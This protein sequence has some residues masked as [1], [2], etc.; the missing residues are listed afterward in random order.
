[1]G[2]KSKNSIL[3]KFINSLSSRRIL[4]KLLLAF[5]CIFVFYFIVYEAYNYVLRPINMNNIPLIKFENCNVKSK[6]QT[7]DGITFSNQNKLIYNNLKKKPVKNNKK[8]IMK[9]EYS[10]EEIFKIL[11]DTKPTKKDINK[12]KEEVKKNH[13][14]L[15]ALKKP[16]NPVK[17]VKKSKNVFSVIE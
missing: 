12:K 16:K 2:R 9:Q 17:A 1:M 14:T 8:E 10:Y 4:Y 7:D 15:K 11:D 3:G 5:I 13:N 6:P